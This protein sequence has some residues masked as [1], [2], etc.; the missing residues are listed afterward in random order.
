MKNT[1]YIASYPPVITSSAKRGIPT[2][3]GKK[4]SLERVIRHALPNNRPRWRKNPSISLPSRNT[5]AL[6]GPNVSQF[7]GR[8]TQTPIVFNT[9]TFLSRRS[10][11]SSFDAP[12]LHRTRLY[13][14]HVTL[15]GKIV[16]FAGYSMPVQYSDLS[17]VESHKW[18]R[19]KASLFDVGHMYALQ[20]LKLDAYRPVN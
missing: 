10:A 3:M 1:K 9:S 19:E 4:T 15:G 8:Q 14:L 12:R 5:S 16:P 2:I 7:R 18:T 13:D 11:S 20:P 17:L 6:S